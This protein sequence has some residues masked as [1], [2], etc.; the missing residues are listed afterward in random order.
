M[1]DSRMGT[2]RVQDGT[3]SNTKK[4]TQNERKRQEKETHTNTVMDKVV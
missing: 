4:E 3:S 1:I 2:E